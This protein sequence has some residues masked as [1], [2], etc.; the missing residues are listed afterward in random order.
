MVLKQYCISDPPTGEH[1]ET[2]MEPTT[3]RRLLETTARHLGLGTAR[4]A[5]I[6][7]GGESGGCAPSAAQEGRM[8]GGGPARMS[9]AAA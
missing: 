5:A 3:I 2:A 7:L 8:K 4:C 9:G 6:R 1:R